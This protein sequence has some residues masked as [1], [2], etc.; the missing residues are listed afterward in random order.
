MKFSRTSQASLLLVALH[1][2][3][4]GISSI[5]ILSSIMYLKLKK[6]KTHTVYFLHVSS[7]HTRHPRTQNEE[8]CSWMKEHLSLAVSVVTRKELEELQTW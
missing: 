6:K 5:H 8:V 2:L 4:G 7:M 3:F 1:F